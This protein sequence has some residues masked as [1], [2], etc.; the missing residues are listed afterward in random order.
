MSYNIHGA[1]CLLETAMVPQVVLIIWPLAS[2][3]FTAEPHRV[4]WGRT[5]TV[6]TV[7]LLFENCSI[8]FQCNKNKQHAQCP[9]FLSQIVRLDVSFFV[10]DVL[11]VDPKAAKML[12]S[13][14]KQTG[15]LIN[16]AMHEMLIY[17]PKAM[18]MIMMTMLMTMMKIKMMMMRTMT[19]TTTR[20]RRMMMMKMKMMMMKMK[21]MMMM[22]PARI[23]AE[24]CVA[25]AHGRKE[26]FP[27]KQQSG[28]VLK[29]TST[30][31]P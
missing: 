18:I 9:L 31:Q 24:T 7:A 28:L 30:G 23:F 15:D 2:W 1:Y 12:W 21:M 13:Q 25:R 20:R 14:P 16:D 27:P 11:Q 10:R 4:Q 3:G 8:L 6:S 5:R 19:T 22:S 29:H 26:P 17:K